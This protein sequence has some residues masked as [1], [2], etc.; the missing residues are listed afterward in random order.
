MFAVAPLLFFGGYMSSNSAI[1]EGDVIRVKVRPSPTIQL[2]HL[3]TGTTLC[4]EGDRV[5][6]EEGQMRLTEIFPENQGRAYV[7][8]YLTPDDRTEF[9]KIVT[10]LRRACR[11]QQRAG[12]YAEALL[13]PSLQ[14]TA[15]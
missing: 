7:K 13:K 14:V 5:V 2:I 15:A 10:I 1:P 11:L 12:R 9:W 8:S 3:P 4:V 6:L